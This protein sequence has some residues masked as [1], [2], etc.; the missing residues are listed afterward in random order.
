MFNS[1]QYTLPSSA[2]LLSKWLFLGVYFHFREF[3]ILKYY[4]LLLP[5]TYLA[6]QRIAFLSFENVLP[7]ISLRVSFL[8]ECYSLS[9]TS[10][11][12][13]SSTKRNSRS[14]ITN[15]AVNTRFYSKSKSRTSRSTSYPCSRSCISQS[16]STSRS[17]N[18]RSVNNHHHN[19]RQPH[20]SRPRPN[21][22]SHSQSPIPPPHHHHYHI[23]PPSDS[24]EIRSNSKLQFSHYL[25]QSSPFIKTNIA[26]SEPIL[27][28]DDD[29]SAEKKEKGRY[30][31]SL[32]ITPAP[33]S[34][35]LSL[36][37]SNTKHYKV[38][39]VTY[40]PKIIDTDTDISDIRIEIIKKRV[41]KLL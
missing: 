24:K 18:H 26:E 31:D 35:Q 34:K 29:E 1:L 32:N 37:L 17:T 8:L 7:S 16:R 28:N 22:P 11:N 21:S 19:R 9:S 4:C 13:P 12:S 30:L 41:A 14:P 6:L 39:D 3:Y 2:L 23:H 40:L 36:N 27:D 10:I 20:H 15:I 38:E 25:Q 33:D 5:T